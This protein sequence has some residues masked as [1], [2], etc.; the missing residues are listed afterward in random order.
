MKNDYQFWKEYLLKT[1]SKIEKLLNESF[2]EGY[3]KK[4]T[5]VYTSP[6]TPNNPYI[7]YSTVSTSTQPNTLTIHSADTA[8]TISSYYNDGDDRK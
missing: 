6:Y 5:Y 1:I 2:W 4:N 3:N 8:T 7:W